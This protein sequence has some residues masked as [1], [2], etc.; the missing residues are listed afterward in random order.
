MTASELTSNVRDELVRLLGNDAADDTIASTCQSIMTTFSLSVEDLNYKWQSFSFNTG[1]N[2]MRLSAENLRRLQ[3]YIQQ[4]LESQPKPK[5]I[6]TGHTPVSVPRSVKKGSPNDLLESMMS[7]PLANKA[8]KL[9]PPGSVRTPSRLGSFDPAKTPGP[10]STNGHTNGNMLDQSVSPPVFQTPV[11]PT[12]KDSGYSS[13]SPT[14]YSKRARDGKA[15]ASVNTGVVERCAPR[16]APPDPSAVELSLGV[17]MKKYTFRTMYQKL[18][19]IAETLDEQIENAIS[20][21]IDA[22]NLSDD[23]IGNPALSTQAEI[24]AVGRV[25]NEHEGEKLSMNSILLESGRRI[26]GGMRARLNMENVPDFSLFPGKVIAVKGSNPD[27]SVFIVK[28]VLEMPIL[29][30][31]A[32][33]KSELRAVIERQDNKPLSIVVASGPY[34]TSDNLLFEPLADLVQHINQTNPDAVI[35]HGPFIDMN[36]PM[37][38][39]GEF[40]VI[41]PFSA[42]DTPVEDATL[43]DV[44]KYTVGYHLKQLH[45][46]NLPVIMI[47][48]V[49]DV[50][51]SHAAFPQPPFNRKSLD[52]PKNFKCLS[53][54]ATFSLNEIVF[55]ATSTDTLADLMRATI[56]PNTTKT[57]NR[58]VVAASNIIS[59][60]SLYPLF[61]SDPSLSVDIP[62]IR[63]ADF[64]HA[65]PDVILTPCTF[66]GMA[67]LVDNVV[68]VSPGLLSKGKSGGT[69][70]TMTIKPPSI[71]DDDNDPLIHKV[72][73]RARVDF[74]KI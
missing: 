67:H 23:Q 60:R 29:N 37:I 66:N 49:N 59:Q 32:S 38:Q 1:E 51:T 8:S 35:L 65:L 15:P 54:P 10:A 17:D 46:P 72:W 33:S 71:S 43:D 61:P 2:D 16:D 42:N 48:S 31:T 28:E 20:T 25:V 19:D 5:K 26:G 53:N 7:T 36:H 63:L 34:T 45:D 74:N 68:I 30:F 4:S 21:I 27:G 50:T 44:F 12:R 69:F 3:E 6:K 55:S 22:Y 11:R 62:Y 13:S 57:S 73:E 14:P 39:S 9:H 47:P 18:S 58:Y 40:D 64:P 41:N 56:Q 24:V 52:L 70:A